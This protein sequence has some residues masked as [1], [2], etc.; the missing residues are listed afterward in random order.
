MKRGGDW[1]RGGKLLAGYD[2]SKKGKYV[3]REWQDYGYRLAM[4][5]GDVKNKSLYMKLA[6]EV[7]RGLLEQARVFVKDATKVRS[8]AK[9]FMWALKKLRK[10]EP[11]YNDKL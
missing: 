3:T 4:E 10:G 9:L 1:Q 8:R 11:L 2:L 6:K 7:E 5:L